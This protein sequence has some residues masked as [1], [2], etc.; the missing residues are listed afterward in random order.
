MVAAGAILPSLAPEEQVGS[1]SGFEPAMLA[2]AVAIE[3]SETTAKEPEVQVFVAEEHL[4]NQVGKL[5]GFEPS[6]LAA[7]PPAMEMSETVAMEP[8]VQIFVAEGQV[9]NLSAEQSMPAAAL[10]TMMA[11]EL[12]LAL[13]PELLQLAFEIQVRNIG[14]SMAAATVQAKMILVLMADS[15]GEKVRVA[16]L[17]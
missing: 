3:M 4:H 6:M 13:V 15:A 1:P 12:M 16:I 8:E 11:A 10:Q 17:P 9:C 5:S 7:S 2:V 14:Q